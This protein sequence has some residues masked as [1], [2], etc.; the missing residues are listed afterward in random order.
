MNKISYKRYRAYK[1]IITIILVAIMSTFVGLGN[2]IGALIVF[3]VA[4]V[5]IFI[6]R[7][8][9]KGVLNDERA[10]N[11]GGKAARIVL[12]VFALLMAVAGI[13]LVSL[14]EQ[15]IQFLIIGNI[16][17]FLECGMMLLYAILFRY[18]SNKKN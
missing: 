11:I 1:L 9:V 5:L 4:I 17:L 10:Y 12:T 15:N 3:G 14:R 2:Y 13:V 18:Y 16:L 6:L 7:K 8:N